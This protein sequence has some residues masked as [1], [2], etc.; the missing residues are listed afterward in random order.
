MKSNQK[1]AVWQKHS[2]HWSRVGAPLRPT[3]E[4]G[5]LMFELAT[6]VLA[7]VHDAQIMVMGVTPEVVQLPWPRGAQLQAFDC[8]EA[9]IASIWRPHAEISSAVQCARWQQLPLQNG[10]MDLIVGDGATTQFAG[11]VDYQEVFSELARVLKPG[12]ALIM[13]C[14]L[15]QQ[16]SDELDA[17]KRSALAG[18]IASFGTLKWRIAMALVGQRSGFG[19]RVTEIF[20]A[21]ESLFPDRDQLSRQAAWPREDID[22]IDAYRG[23]EACYTFPTLAELLQIIAPW[24]ELAAVRHGTYELADCCPTIALH[25]LSTTNP[26]LVS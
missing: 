22:T 4:D 17:I 10:A 24:F 26:G 21:F 20:A 9:M 2:T 8:S 6:P 5:C 13:R 3:E 19:I 12:G 7:G 18:E 14:F 1:S 11:L 15:R 25:R 23:A 16:S